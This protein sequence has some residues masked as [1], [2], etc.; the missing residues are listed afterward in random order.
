MKQIIQNILTKNFAQKYFISKRGLLAINKA[1]LVNPFITRTKL[2][3]DLQ[4]VASVRT[5]SKAIQLLGWRRVLTKY[6]Q[7]V[8]PRNRVKRF[9]YCGFCRNMGKISRIP[10]MRMKQ[11]LNLDF[12][13]ILIIEK[14][15]L[16]YCSLLV[17]NWE[18]QR[19]ILRFIYLEVFQDT[20]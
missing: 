16:I 11:W 18:N 7:I 17:E 3:L 9:I 8:E 19:T 5:I 20:A 13:K 4:L 6:C 15:M 1:L 10:S 14:I 12:P 2:K